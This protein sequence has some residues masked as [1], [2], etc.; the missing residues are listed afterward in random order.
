MFSN[1]CVVY[2]RVEMNEITRTLSMWDNG[3]AGIFQKLVCGS[4]CMRNF[5][6][7]FFGK[8]T[9]DRLFKINLFC[10]QIV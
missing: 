7:F 6:F 4:D 10:V 5:F 9:F 3:C 1:E 2:S 8:E